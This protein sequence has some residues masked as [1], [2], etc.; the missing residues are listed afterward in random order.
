[1][2]F[3]HLSK[4]LRVKL[5]SGFTLIELLVVI[6]I[7][8]ILI[9]VISINFTVAQKQ[10]RDARRRQDMSLSQSALEQYYAVNG[11]Y[12]VSGSASLAFD[13]GSLP[14][15]PKN[16]GSYTYTWN[17]SASAYCICATLEKAGGNATSPTGTTCNWTTGS[18]ATYVCIQ[19][20][21]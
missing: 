1:M 8:G 21:Q 20:Q 14:T 3:Q 12:P 19:N 10:A 4:N 11:A 16:S 9:A 17:T 2:T 18:S 7:I 15:D 5:K 13:S 6:A